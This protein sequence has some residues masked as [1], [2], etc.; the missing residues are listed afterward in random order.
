[1]IS[2]QVSALAGVGGMMAMAVGPVATGGVA[3]QA[4]SIN[5]AR[6]QWRDDREVG[7]AARASHPHAQIGPRQPVES[8][9]RRYHTAPG[10]RR[11]GGRAPAVG[12]VTVLRRAARG[13]RLKSRLWALTATKPAGAGSGQSDPIRLMGSQILP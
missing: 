10:R 4:A 6:Q 8:G 1:M 12:R 5:A 2:V 13:R 11:A 9:R 3:A 7:Q